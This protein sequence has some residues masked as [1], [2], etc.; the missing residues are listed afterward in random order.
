ME[1][2]FSEALATE[3]TEFTE[4]FLLSPSTRQPL[5]QPGYVAM[6]KQVRLCVL[7]DLCGRNFLTSGRPKRSMAK[8]APGPD[9]AIHDGINPTA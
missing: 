1:R 7:G 2:V 4:R 5:L 9:N 8:Q 6:G 3:G